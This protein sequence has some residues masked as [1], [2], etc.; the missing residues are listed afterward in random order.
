[1]NCHA[2]ETRWSGTD[3]CFNCGQPGTFDAM[4][5][6]LTLPHTHEQAN[7]HSLRLEA[8]GRVE[9]W[10]Q[11]SPWAAWV[12]EQLCAR[13]PWL[14]LEAGHIDSALGMW[15]CCLLVTVVLVGWGVL[16]AGGAR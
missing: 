15:A 3:P 5:L 8:D 11:R 14:R 4:P 16:G 7:P 1:M 13:L 6:K 12:R 9:G 10:E 2:C